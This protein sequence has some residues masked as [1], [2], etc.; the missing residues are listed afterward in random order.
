MAALA[1]CV[2]EGLASTR[3]FELLLMFLDDKQ[4]ALVKRVFK[5]LERLGAPASERLKGVWEQK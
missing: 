1:T 5:E 4:K 2:L 3:R